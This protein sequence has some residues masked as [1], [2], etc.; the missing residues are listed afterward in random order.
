MNNGCDRC[1]D[2]DDR[3]DDDNDDDKKTSEMHVASRISQT[4]TDCLHTPEKHLSLDRCNNDK[5]QVAS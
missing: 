4:A 1:D 5:I 3:C 2:D